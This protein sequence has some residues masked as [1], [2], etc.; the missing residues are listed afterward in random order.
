MGYEDY[1]YG[2]GVTVIEWSDMIR[3]LIPDNAIRIRLKKDAGKGFD[4]RRIEIDDQP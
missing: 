2:D 1:F 3:E 4:Y